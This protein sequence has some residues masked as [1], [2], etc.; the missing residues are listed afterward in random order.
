MTQVSST[1]DRRPGFLN[2][3][4]TAP[5]Y[6]ENKGASFFAVKGVVV[7]TAVSV[8]PDELHPAPQSW[9]ERAYPKLI[10]YNKVEKGGHFVVWEQPELF[11]AE[12][13]ASFKSLR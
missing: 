9:A 5:L 1:A 13:R 12:L 11:T 8:F 2:S 3:A 6:W 10:H 4:A 7:P